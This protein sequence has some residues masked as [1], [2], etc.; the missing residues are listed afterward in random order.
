MIR[1]L[2]EERE[3]VASYI[4]SMCAVA[5][6]RSKDYLI[7]GR[8]GHLAEQSGCKSYSQ[9]VRMARS[10]PAG[11]MGRRMVDEITT[12]ETL[13]FRDSAP[14][15]LLRFKIIPEIVDRRARSGARAMIR[16]WS[17]ACSTGQELYRIAMTLKETLG[18]LSGYDVRLIGTDI[19]DQAVARAS[20][21]IFG[22]IDISRGLTAAMR[23]KYFLPHTGGSWKIR[24]EIRAMASFRRLNLMQDLSALGNFD[25]IFCRNVAIYFNDADRAA[26][27]RS[28]GQRLTPDGYLIIGSMESLNRISPQ[29]ESNRH[30][31]SVFYQLT[32]TGG[33]PRRRPI[34]G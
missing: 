23:S 24:D 1:L 16:I 18:D 34:T 3:E 10:D 31:R 32:Q 7:E 17:A 2:P 22:Q 28:I 20:A 26:L 4:Y 11:R 14:F 21:G 12:G 25:V 33:M 15:D 9:L 30:M 13:F 6:D 29:F 27:F 8:L 5:L 19:S